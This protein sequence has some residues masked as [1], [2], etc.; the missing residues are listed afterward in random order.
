[1]E[2]P[3]EPDFTGSGPSLYLAG[4]VDSWPNWQFPATILLAQAGFAGTVLSPRPALN[5]ADPYGAWRPFGWHSR[6]L[7][8]CDLVLFFRPAGPVQVLDTYTANAADPTRPGVVVG[9]DQQSLAADRIRAA[10][11][12]LTVHTDLAATVAAALAELRTRP[13]PRAAVPS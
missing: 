12:W 9:C 3:E 10:A 6:N 4:S 1:M 5:P 11:P 13:G 8:R 7:R 2:Y